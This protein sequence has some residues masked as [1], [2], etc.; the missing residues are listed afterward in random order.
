MQTVFFTLVV[1]F[2][3]WSVPNYRVIDRAATA[4]LEEN[5]PHFLGKGVGVV[6]SFPRFAYHTKVNLFLVWATS[7]CGTVAWCCYGTNL[8]G[9]SMR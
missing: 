4:A 3:I 1:F 7:I 2:L 8:Y 6:Y 5:T 9:I